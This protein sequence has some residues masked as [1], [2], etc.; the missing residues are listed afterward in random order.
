MK[1]EHAMR[2]VC[3]LALAAAGLTLAA[4]GGSKPAPAPGSPEKPL[5]AEQ[6]RLGATGSGARNNEAAGSASQAKPGYESLVKKQSSHP[7]SRFTP[8]NLVTAS[9]ARAILGAAI[10]D[11]VEAP[12][13]PTCIYRSRNG[14]SFVS[15]AVQ[16]GNFDKLKGQL[17]LRHRVNVSSRTAYCGTYGQPMLYLR[18]SGGRVLSVAAQ[19][20]VAK[21][22]ATKAVRQLSA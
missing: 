3:L 18:L 19:C 2:L 22:F 17:R 1:K 10:E 11:P 14:K 9:Q 12:Q 5:V 7:R 6:T 15:V 8:C 4:C 16:Q 20:E 21:Q 13:G